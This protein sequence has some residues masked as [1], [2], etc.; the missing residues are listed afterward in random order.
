MT[1]NVG[2][3]TRAPRERGNFGYAT[4]EA[5]VLKSSPRLCAART[6]AWSI[7]VGL[8]RWGCSGGGAVQVGR[9]GLEPA[10]NGLSSP[11]PA[12]ALDISKRCIQAGSE[13]AESASTQFTRRVAASI[14]AFCTR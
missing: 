3:L 6:A 7:V 11:Y 1:S 14:V 13:R 12:F 8:F 4:V 5:S 9:A 2:A 10:T